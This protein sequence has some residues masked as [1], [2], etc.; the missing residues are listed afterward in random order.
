MYKEISSALRRLGAPTTWTAVAFTLAL[1]ACNDDENTRPKT[2][3]SA[4]TPAKANRVTIKAS[5]NENQRDP[6]VQSEPRS[7]VSAKG[8]LVKLAS[9]E[10]DRTRLDAATSISDA[11]ALP[12]GPQFSDAELPFSVKRLTVTTG[13]EN[14]EPKEIDGFELGQSPIYAFVELSNPSD[15]P[16][17]V[18]ITFENPEGPAV[19]HVTLSV[20]ANQPRWRTWGRTRM[21]QNAGEW[22]AVVKTVEGDEIVRQSFSVESS[23]TNDTSETLSPQKKEQPSS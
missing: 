21:V 22:N 3:S 8:E 7:S 17:E 5:G 15:E 18:V 20:P 10:I 23:G 19:G 2:A 12:S 11:N 4:R 13:I 9:A 1:T 14:R 16:H 6:V